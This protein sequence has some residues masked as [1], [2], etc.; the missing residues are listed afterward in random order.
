MRIVH[1]SPGYDPVVGGSEIHIQ[2]LSEGLARR[3]HDVTVLTEVP[4]HPR[5]PIGQEV[6]NS[7]RVVRFPKN[8][9]VQRLLA[10]PGAYRILAAM[11]GRGYLRM[12]DRGPL[13]VR[14]FRKLLGCR[15]DIV[16]VIGWWASVLPLKVCV[17]KRMGGF[18]VVGIPLFH[19]EE[20]WSHESVYPN[21]L[22]QC[23]AVLAN[24]TYEQRFIEARASQP[25]PVHTVG[26]GIHPS[27]FL[28]RDGASLRIR[29]GL[30]DAPVVGYVGRIIPGKG[31]PGLIDAM[32]FVWRWNDRVRL[33]LAVSRALQGTE[34]GRV[35][36]AALGRLSPGE[37]T[38]VVEIDGFEERD[39][40]SIFDAFDV[41]AMPSTGESFGIAY[42]EAWACRKPV[43]GGRIGSTQCVIEEGKDGLLVDPHDAGEIATAIIRLLADPEERS[44]M[45]QAGYEKILSRFT[46]DKITERVE[47]IYRGLATSPTE[48]PRPTA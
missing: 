17:A 25:V 1:V 2:E 35:I 46:W 28:S 9:T 39:K 36:E 14:M 8:Q 45:G 48:S 26:V 10:L 18:R 11:L 7:V 20:G 38:R 43:I 37:R 5:R 3:G 44:R 6:I 33:V 4:T 13:S 23:D 47:A 30:D 24:T 42:L 32:K 15:A 34:T 21:L 22:A 27:R 12:L 41:F 29:Y 16:G 40:S 19:T 31:V